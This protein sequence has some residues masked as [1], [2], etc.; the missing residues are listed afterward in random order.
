[1]YKA[2]LFKKKKKLLLRIYTGLGPS[3]CCHKGADDKAS[4]LKRHFLLHVA[5]N[6]TIPFLLHVATNSGACPLG[7]IPHPHSCKQL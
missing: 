4:S 6:S 3:M 1:M 5:T 7:T 2:L